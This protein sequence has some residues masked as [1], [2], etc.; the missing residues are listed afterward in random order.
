MDIS[1]TYIVQISLCSIRLLLHKPTSLGDMC[2]LRNLNWK[3]VVFV[4][5]KLCLLVS[6]NSMNIEENDYQNEL[7]AEGSNSK[8]GL[9]PTESQEG[10]ADCAPAQVSTIMA[11]ITCTGPQQSASTSGPHL[12]YCTAAAQRTYSASVPKSSSITS[13]QDPSSSTSIPPPNFT[14]PQ[15]SCSTS[16]PEPR[17]STSLPAP[18]HPKLSTLE[19]QQNFKEELSLVWQ[20]KVICSLDLLLA[21]FKKC[22][23]PGCTNGTTIKHHIIGTT[24]VIKWCCTSGHKE[25]F[26]SKDLNEIYSNNL[27]VAASIMLSGNNFAKVEKRANFLGLSFISDS[28]SIQ[29]LFF[30][31][32]ISEQWSWQREQ[33]LKEFVGRGHRLW[34]WPVWLPRSRCQESVLFSHGAC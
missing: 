18:A 15:P 16:G 12:S 28:T 10:A 14:I 2:T 30:I 7:Q 19:E 4:N 31:P 23:H 24:A 20:V 25:T 32:A 9:V 27:Q 5:W 34:G 33:L 26:S 13:P 29:R 21:V 3:E 22:Q 17:S 6:R 8:S 1:F 11:N